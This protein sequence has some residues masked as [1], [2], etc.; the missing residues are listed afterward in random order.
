M[1]DYLLKA[2]AAMSMYVLYLF[3]DSTGG[4]SQDT[5]RLVAD[6]FR[7]VRTDPDCRIYDGKHAE[8]R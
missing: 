6:S 7:G 4:G 2:V 3:D 8:K 1:K 5:L